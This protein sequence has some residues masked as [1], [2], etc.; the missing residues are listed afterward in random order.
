MEIYDVA[1][2]G[3]GPA[4]MTAALYASRAGLS[5]VVFERMMAG[6][7]M[8]ETGQIDNY[9]GFPDGVGGF[10]LSLAMQQQDER[11]GTVWRNEEVVSLDVKAD[12]KV[13]HT[14]TGE[15]GARAVILAPG[16]RSRKLGVEG[17][18]ELAGRGVS[19]CATCDGNFFA[20]KPV[21]VVGGG[22]TAAAD[23]AYLSRICS[24]VT[25]VHRRDEL[26]ATAASAH[27][28]LTAD[29]VEFAWDSVVDR[30]LEAD[31]KLA[32]A[33]IRN[34]KTGAESTIDAAGLFVAVGKQPNTESFAGAVPLDDSGYLVAGEDG[35]TEIP[36]VFAAGDA[37][38][39]RLRQVSTAIADGANAAEEAAAWL[40]S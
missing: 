27:A 19:Y 33:V 24:K 40:A 17:E 21:I 23:A 7:Q 3:G 5:T 34:V 4:G 8:G 12:P 2:V 14:P 38:T 30:L 39:K 32:G 15:V 26:R 28:A 22:N 11:F 36:G 20:G 13:V 35:I 9:P 16:A 6:G 37:R 29:N 1:I 18:A 25:V 10:D 31:G